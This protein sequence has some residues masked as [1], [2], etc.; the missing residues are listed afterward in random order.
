M[1]RI[2]LGFRFMPTEEELIHY[3]WTKVVDLTLPFPGVVIERDLYGDKAPWE[4]FNNEV[5]NPWVTIKGKKKTT[6]TIYV[7][8]RLKKIGPKQNIRK[9]GCGAWDTQTGA[10]QIKNDHKEVIGFKRMLVFQVKGDLHVENN[11]HWMMHEDSLPAVSLIGL[12]VY[13]SKCLRRYE[14]PAA[15]TDRA[16]ESEPCVV[17]RSQECG[18]RR[19]TFEEE[20]SRRTK[21]RCGS[22]ITKISIELDSAI[23]P[24]ASSPAL[25]P[26]RLDDFETCC[27]SVAP[28]KSDE[29]VSTIM[30]I[31]SAAEEVASL[32]SW[33]DDKNIYEIFDD[34][35]FQS[36]LNDLFQL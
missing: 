20:N 14:V 9:A 34:Q 22:D 11:S 33:S 5:P 13:D 19:P 35:T 1:S 4:V 12:Q 15:S 17:E 21:V 16:T 29:L 31:P 32:P 30:S 25:Q 26:N 8:T 10:V 18:K 7:L 2:P 28:P 23:I 24:V 3:L 6:N 36:F 27:G